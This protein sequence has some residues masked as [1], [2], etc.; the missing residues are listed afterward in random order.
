MPVASSRCSACPVASVCC[1]ATPV[2]SA[3]CSASLGRFCALLCHADCFR[4]L[5]W[6]ACHFRAL[7]RLP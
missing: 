5:Q 1:S 6:F 7:L 2:A 4:A 3:L